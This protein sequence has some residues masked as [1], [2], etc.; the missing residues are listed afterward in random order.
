MVFDE[1]K[2]DNSPYELRCFLNNVHRTELGHFTCNV[3]Y[4]ILAINSFDDVALFTKNYVGACGKSI[5]VNPEGRFSFSWPTTYHNDKNSV[6]V[7]SFTGIREILTEGD[8][9]EEDQIVVD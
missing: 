5:T 4:P 3:K 2:C 7:F 1:N 6:H 9:T 8:L